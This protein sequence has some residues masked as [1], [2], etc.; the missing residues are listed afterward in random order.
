[1]REQ[2]AADTTFANRAA[3][4]YE[5]RA[6]PG[7]N[8]WLTVFWRKQDTLYVAAV[9]LLSSLRRQSSTNN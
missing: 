7:S 5:Q 3:R 4:D 2:A 1:M 8:Y 9:H 6:N